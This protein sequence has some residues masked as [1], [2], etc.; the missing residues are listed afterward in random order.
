MSD[1]LLEEYVAQ[2]IQANSVSQVDFCWHGGEPL[3]AGIEF[4]K[5]A[6]KLQQK[7]KGEKTINN[8]LQTN[9]LLLTDD[10][11]KFFSDNNFLIGLSIDG[12]EAVHNATRRAVSGEPTFQKVMQGVEKL[13]RAQTEFNTLSAVSSF[14]Q[15]RAVETYRFLKS[16]GSHFMQFLPVVEYRKDGIIANPS[17]GGERAEWSISGVGYGRFLKDVFDEWVVQDV[18]TYYVQMFDATLAGW[19]GVQPGICAFCESCGDGLV[20]EHNGDVYSCDHFV[21]PEYRLGNIQ[22][23]NL[24]GMFASRAQFAFGVNKR[25]ALPQSCERCQWLHLC[26]GECPKHRFDDGVNALCEGFQSYFKYTKPYMEYM[27]Q[28]LESGMPPSNVMQFARQR[29]GL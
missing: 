22:N 18:G 27:R 1:E 9:G 17:Q 5:K 2:Y 20:V 3:I 24:K 25:N 14:S 8:T 11:C 16:I 29:M 21:Y 19:C 6:L 26:H 4:Y 15:G 28:C 7:Y 23:D 12:V 13:H 10:F